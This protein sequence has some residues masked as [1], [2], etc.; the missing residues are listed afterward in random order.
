MICV[1][2]AHPYR[3]RSLATRALAAALSEVGGVELRQLYDLYPDFDIDVDAEQQ[4]LERAQLVVWLHPLYWY[5][6]PSLLKHWFEKVLAYGFAYGERGTALHGKHCLWVPTAGGREQTY[7]PGGLHARPFASYAQVIEQ[8]ARFCGMQW[9]PPYVVYAA[10]ELDAGT[11]AR[12]AA[13]LVD[14]VRPWA[15]PAPQSTSGARP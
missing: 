8:T 12:H 5:S 11:L 2:H 9:L 1:I 15:Q 10:S 7:V 14:R 6:V 13:A 3:G 4:A